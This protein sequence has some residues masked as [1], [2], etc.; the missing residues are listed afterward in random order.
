MRLSGS[1]NQHHTSLAL[2]LQR[3]L[4]DSSQGTHTTTTTTTTQ[5]SLHFQF[6]DTPQRFE[7]PHYT[8]SLPATG[9]TI[10][11]ASLNTSTNGPSIRSSYQGVI[12][13]PPPSGPAANSPTY[14]QWAL[15]SVSAP[16]INAFQQD[17][18][19]KESVLKVQSTGGMLHSFLF[20]EH[21]C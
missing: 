16:L 13:S 14:A 19:S 18:G 4:P 12:N 5:L 15:F 20:W 17:S 6:A 3:H 8:R 2:G 21:R 9:Y 1:Q 7:L 10:I 11:M